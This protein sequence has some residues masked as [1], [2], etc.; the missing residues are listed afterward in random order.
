MFSRKKA[1]LAAFFRSLGTIGPRYSKKDR[2]RDFRSVFGTEAGKRVLTQIIAESDK[3]VLDTELQA[4]LMAY[5]AGKRS[6][7]LWLVK[8][9]NAEP[10]E[11]QP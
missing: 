2:Y 7:G 9:L 11:E 6:I 4:E 3:P 8:V 10:L 1:D 5:R